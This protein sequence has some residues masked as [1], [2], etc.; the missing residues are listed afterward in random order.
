MSSQDALSA[1]RNAVKS[2]YQIKGVDSDNVPSPTLLLATHLQL[3][4]T[5]TLPKSTPTRLRRPGSTESDPSVHPDTFFS[6]EAVY[7]AWLSRDATG[8][9]YMRQA[10]DS[11]LAV[12]FVSVTERKNVV[13]WL[14]GKVSHLDNVVPA[15]T[16]S[17][18]PPGTPPPAAYFRTH[19]RT[20][21]FSSFPQSSSSSHAHHA[22]HGDMFSPSKRRYVPDVQ[23]LEVVKKIR[24]NEVELRDRNTVLRGI[25]PNNFT[26]IK[27]VYEAKLKSL[28]DSKKTGK[29]PAVAAP[30]PDAKILARK[31]KNFYPI[32]MISSSPTALVTMHN[33]KRFLEDATCACA[34]SSRGQHAPR[35]PDPDLPAPHDN[36]PSGRETTTSQRYYVVDSVDA[37]NK[38]GAD[39]WDRV[40]CVM[41]TGQ[42]WQFRPYKWKEPLS[43]FHHGTDM[44]THCVCAV[45]GVYVSWTIDPPNSKIKDW[46]VTEI[47]VSQMRYDRHRPDLFNSSARPA[48]RPAP[49]ACRQ[50]HRRALLEDAGY[51]DDAQQTVPD[52]ELKTRAASARIGAPDM[53][54]VKIGTLL[55]RTLAKPISAQIKAQAKEHERFRNICV[56]LAQTMYRYEVRLRTNLLG[57]PAKHVRPLSETRAIENGA[58]FLAEGFLFTVAAGLI[59]TETWRASRSSSKRRDDVDERI[60]DVSNRVQKLSAWA[61]ESE[62]R[63]RDEIQKNEELTRILDRVVEIGLRGGWAELED[64]PLRIPRPLRSLP[65]PPSS[66]QSPSDSSSSNSRPPSSSDPSP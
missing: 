8:A 2:K 66:S 7:L 36:R 26:S 54:T 34:R 44:R 33:V 55:I 37:L 63:L 10:R 42:A 49:P 24:Q 19:G 53:A 31:Q 41:T 39:A 21:A 58:N 6:L 45:K 38:F 57:E 32:I 15:I 48:D 51:V 20:D 50:G 17:T 23:D 16:E 22:G 1:L 5:L 12:G 61:E 52:E 27:N 64:T 46:N 62:T 9:E 11:G 60:E 14:E 43:L 4:D 13:E 25:K 35:G 29:A 56:S 47:K 65:P 59:L 18:T 3:S 28:K 40:V 30:S